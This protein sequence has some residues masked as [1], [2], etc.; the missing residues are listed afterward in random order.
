M[1]LIRCSNFGLETNLGKAVFYISMS[2]LSNVTSIFF[3]LVLYPRCTC[4]KQRF[5]YWQIMIQILGLHWILALGVTKINKQKNKN[6]IIPTLF[7]KGR[8]TQYDFFTCDKFT[9]WQACDMNQ[10]YNLLTTVVYVKKI[11]VHPCRILK[12]VLK[13]CDNRNRNL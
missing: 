7:S 12:H 9:C 2:V 8:F 5:D 11:V 3:I 6:I 4:I 10:T 1:L 13:R